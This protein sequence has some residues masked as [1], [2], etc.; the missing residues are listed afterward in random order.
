MIITDR[1]TVTVRIGTFERSYF[2][3]QT[4]APKAYD[5]HGT[6]EL[7]DNGADGRYVLVDC[8]NYDYQLGRNNSGLFNLDKEEGLTEWAEE[9][10]YKRM[11]GE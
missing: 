11:K 10:L 7:I 4:K 1:L 2:V 5:Y 8:N 3:C 9:I 6:I